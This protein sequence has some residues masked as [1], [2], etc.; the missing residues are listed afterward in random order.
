MGLEPTASLVLSQVGLPIAYR[1]MSLFNR[2][3]QGRSR[4]CKH[5]GLSRTALPLAYSGASSPGR[6]RTTGGRFVGA[7]PLPLGDGTV[8]K[9]KWTHRELHPNLL[10]AEQVS[11]CW[12]MSPIESRR[13]R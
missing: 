10:R 6:T 12:T 3:A 1:A 8:C 7:L 2:S 4:T 13:K 5:S 11:S 9:V